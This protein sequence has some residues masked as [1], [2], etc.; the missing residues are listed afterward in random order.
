MVSENDW[1]AINPRASVT[2]TPNDEAPY[3]VGIPEINP[4]ADRVRP[5]GSAPEMRDQ[6]KGGAPPLAASVCE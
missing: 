1:L 5:A 2:T 6:V 4:P 3:A